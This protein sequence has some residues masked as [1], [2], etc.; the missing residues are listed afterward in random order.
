ML[1]INA[2][3]FTERKLWPMIKRKL[4]V[5]DKITHSKVMIH[6]LSEKLVIR[7]TRAKYVH[8]SS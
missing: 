6:V 5:T 4:M 1:Y 8:P 3:C 2:Q 7:N